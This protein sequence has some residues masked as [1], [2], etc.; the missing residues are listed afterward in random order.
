[1]ASPQPAPLPLLPELP[2]PEPDES[3]PDGTEPDD[4]SDARQNFFTLKSD[5]GIYD[6]TDLNERLRKR[7][8]RDYLLDGMIPP[9]SVNILVGDSGIGKSALVYQLA[10]S[11]AAGRPFLGHRP[12]AGGGKVI[13]VDYENPIAESHRILRQQRRFMGIDPDDRLYR[14]LVWAMTEEAGRD[15]LSED[16]AAHSSH[17]NVQHII[18][19]FAPDLVIFDS[20]RSFH[21]AM[22]NEN[23]AAASQIQEMRAMARRTGM[24]ILFVHHVRKTLGQT[25]QLEDTPPLDWL[26]RSAGARALINQTDARLAVSTR[27]GDPNT[28]VL[29]GHVRTHGEVGPYFLER[30]W[31]DDGEPL[32]YRRIVM[33]PSMLKN[34]AQEA[35]FA[36]LPSEFSFKDARLLY[37]R[38]NEATS[39]FLRKLV[40]EGLVQKDG[41]GWY[42]KCNDEPK[43][44]EN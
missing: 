42:R 10:L 4:E 24:A 3:E 28:L 37:G 13:L 23:G 29:R 22:E 2:L 26:V 8:S 38:Q 16:L 18:D 11:V 25:L 34:A 32:G 21:P 7:P 44:G 35:T 14:M 36:A 27:R 40:R 20:L 39:K 31:D 33:A 6:W 5:L 19:S 41:P 30:V 12:Q 17:K 43:L 15:N 1:M 9:G